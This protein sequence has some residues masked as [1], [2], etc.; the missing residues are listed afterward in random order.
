MKLLIE[1]NNTDLANTLGNLVNRTIGMANKYRSGLIKK[2]KT[3]K[4][5][6]EINLVT[7]C[8]N[9]LSTVRAKMDEY[10]VSDALEAVMKVTRLANKFIDV[11]EPWKLFK[12]EE[13]QAE[14][15]G[16]LYELIETIRVIAVLLQAFM[17]ETSKEILSQINTTETDFS[18]VVTFGGFKDQTVLNKPS[19]LFERYDADLKIEEILRG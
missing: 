16:V 1:R 17:P 10:R 6:Y 12:D 4:E 2:A 5:T 9:L 11:T 13:R 18:S 3:T 15:D 8:E 14:L 19:V 7:E